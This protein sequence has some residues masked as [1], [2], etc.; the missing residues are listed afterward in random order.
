MATLN[1]VVPARLKPAPVLDGPV[2]VMVENE[3]PSTVT[4]PPFRF[5]VRKLAELL[6]VPVMV[7]PPRVRLPI[8]LFVVVAVISSKPP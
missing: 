3:L 1:V 7:P 8:A 4:V 2:L 6:G 5:Q